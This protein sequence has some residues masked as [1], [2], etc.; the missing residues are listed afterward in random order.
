MYI[1]VKINIKREQTDNTSAGFVEKARKGGVG[2][3]VGH[4]PLP[5]HPKRIPRLR[6]SCAWERGKSADPALI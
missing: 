3:N 6:W 4:K 1:H 5:R 2:L